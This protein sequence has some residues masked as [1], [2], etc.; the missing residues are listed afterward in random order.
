MAELADALGLGP[1]VRKD[2]G[3]R[4]PPPAPCTGVPNVRSRRFSS[5]GET[6]PG[7]HV[8]VSLDVCH[9]CRCI[10][11]TISTSSSKNVACRR[12]SCFSRRSAGLRR[13]ALI[14]ETDTYLSELI[15]EVGEP[16]ADEIAELRPSIG[17][18]SSI[19]S[20]IEQADQ[21]LMLDSGASRDW[22]DGID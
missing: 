7:P 16:T 20:R 4:V 22:R 3:V 8:C 15:D 10:F 14:D 9:G 21:M 1:S 17:N 11:P 19:T 2:L 6:L 18:S 5:V 13:Q 12:L